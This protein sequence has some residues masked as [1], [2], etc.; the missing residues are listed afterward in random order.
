MV[1]VDERLQAHGLLASDT[2][3]NIIGVVLEALGGLLLEPDHVVG[4][5]VSEADAGLQVTQSLVGRHLDVLDVTT[6]L[7]GKLGG[8]L[9][10]SEKSVSV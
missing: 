3:D 2:L 5:V 6:E 10:V 8:D 4:V 7:L 1:L 9:G